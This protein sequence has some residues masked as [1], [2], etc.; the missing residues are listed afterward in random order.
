VRRDSTAVGTAAPPICRHDV[1]QWSSRARSSLH[2]APQ[3]TLTLRPHREGL[4]CATGRPE[5]T[6]GTLHTQISS[7]PLVVE[8]SRRLRS[9]IDGTSAPHT[10]SNAL[11][12]LRT[13]G[14]HT[15]GR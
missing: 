8:C 4:L 5:R 11:K 12:Q 6:R 14:E 2:L 9:A 1:R 3:T 10:G 13:R 7:A 15:Y